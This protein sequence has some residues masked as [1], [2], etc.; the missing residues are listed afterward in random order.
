L[1][2]YGVSKNNLKK[3]II[4]V[5]S[6]SEQSAIATILSDTDALI[7]S[8]DGLIEKKKAIKQGTMQ[9]LLTGKRRLPGFSGKW[10]EKKI[11]ET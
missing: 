5:P 10:E 4:P 7:V 8:L 9:E 6:K 3:V 2:V 11:S 1:K